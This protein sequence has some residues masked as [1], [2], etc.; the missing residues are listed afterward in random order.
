MLFLAVL[1]VAIAVFAHDGLLTLLDRSADTFRRWRSRSGGTP[2]PAAESLLAER[3]ELRRALGE[4]WERATIYAIGRAV[5]DYL[6]LLAAVAA[7]GSDARPSLVLLAFAGAQVLGM[8][9]FTPGGVGF[10]EAGL[11]GMLALAGVSPADAISAALALPAHVLLVA[12][13]GGPPGR[14]AP[15]TSLRDG[16]I[17]VTCT[18]SPHQRHGAANREGV[19]P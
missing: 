14:P 7:F 17:G 6:T 1:L 16:T 10:V 8:I 9:P 12:H 15:S 13:P 5:F 4:Q 3:D 2:R 18:G 11:T 19:S